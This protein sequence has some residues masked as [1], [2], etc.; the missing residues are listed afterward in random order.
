MKK[1]TSKTVAMALAALVAVGSMTL[2]TSALGY[3]VSESTY[4]GGYAEAAD[5]GAAEGTVAASLRTST[6]PPN[7]SNRL[8][9]NYKYIRSVSDKSVYSYERPSVYLN[10][11]RSAVNGLIIGGVPYLPFR[12]VA[13]LLGARYSYNASTKTSVMTLSGVEISAVGGNY[14]LYANGRVLFSEMPTVI[15][16]DGRM[17]V[18]AASLAKALGLTAELSGG[19]LNLRGSVTPLASAASYYREDEVFWLARIIHAESSGEPLLGKIAVGNVVLNRVRSREYPNTIYGV[20]FDRKYGVQ[21]SPILNGSI[22]NQ[23]S[24]QSRL[25]AMICLEGFD[26]SQGALFFLRPELSTSSWIPKTRQY[27][28]TVGKHDFYY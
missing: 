15:M 5:Y 22:Y 10:G 13:N 21:F 26:T 1:R 27:A 17:Y 24:Y 14:T 8:V 16:N 28:F 19:S 23:P 18:V 12:A 9:R 25:A 20:I 4:E 7:G 2:S 6:E 11:R 3:N